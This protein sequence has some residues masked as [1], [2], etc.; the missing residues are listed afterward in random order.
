MDGD[1]AR[2]LARTRWPRTAATSRGYC[3]WLATH[4]H[5][6]RPSIGAASRPLRRRAPQRRAAPASVARQLA[7]I[8]MLHRFLVEE[9]AARRRPDRRPRR[10]SGAG[11]HPQAA[12][13]GRGRRAARRGRRQR[14]GGLPRPGAAR[15]AVRHRA[16]ICEAVR[17]VARRRR[18]STSGWSGCSARARRSGS[19]PSAAAPRRRWREWLGAVADGRTWSRERWARRGDAEAVFLNTAG[20]RL[21]ARSAWAVVKQ[22]GE[23][24]GIGRASCRRTSCATRAPPTCSTTAPTCASCRSCSATRRSRRRRCTPRSARSGCWTSTAPR[25]RGRRPMSAVTRGAPRPALRRFAVA[26]RARPQRTPRGPTLI[27]CSAE[28]RTVAPDVGRRPRHSIAVARR[29][30]SSG[31]ATRDEIA[32]ALLHDVGK[33]E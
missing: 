27:S 2:A 9:G 7:A 26:P 19:C 11:R 31:S 14:P 23:R 18:S 20:A 30:E 6:A 29:F 16:R 28:A 12:H 13:R 32:G 17:S 15:V 21:A 10:R 5:A 22:Y 3:A 33:I 1:R 25:T 24:A 8:R 4:G